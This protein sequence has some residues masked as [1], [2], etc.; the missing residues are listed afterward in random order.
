MK[1][2][3]TLIASATLAS[4][5]ATNVTV[6]S[7]KVEYRIGGTNRYETSNM[8]ANHIY[9]KNV[10]NVILV[11]G[12]APYDALVSSSF[13]KK[14]N[15]PILLTGTNK[16]ESG[17]S[18]NYIK[19]HLKKSG[20]VYILGGNA[21]VSSDT[22]SEIK[23]LGFKI[24]RIC[25]NDRFDTNSKIINELNVKKG[26]PIF[27]VSSNGFGDSLSV[28][29][30]SAIKEY[31]I[32]M[33]GKDKLPTSL[34]NQIE[35]IQPSKVYII[36]S[37]SLISDKVVSEIKNLNK[38]LNESDMLRIYGK[39][40]YQTNLLINKAFN[41]KSS[42]DIIAN[43]EN[44]ADALSGSVLAS[45]LNAPIILTDGKNF[46][47]QKSYINSTNYINHYILGLNGSV[48]KSIENM[49][50]NHNDNKD[51]HEFFS[52]IIN[53]KHVT[54]CELDSTCTIRFSAKDLP[55][56][57]QNGFNQATAMIGDTITLG[58]TG[59]FKCDSDTKIK[60]ELTGTIKLNGMLPVNKLE[61]PMWV[62]IDAS[63][64]LQ[65]KVKCIYKI[66][67]E[68]LAK[69]P[70]SQ[71]VIK[72]LDNK[73]YMVMNLSDMSDMSNLNNGTE[74]VSVDYNKIIGYL[75][76]NK[77]LL[78]KLSAKFA[79][80]FTPN[81]NAIKKQGNIKTPDGRDAVR[82]QLKL[83]TNSLNELIAYT[84]NNALNF[85][86]E[87]EVVDF[88]KAY[89]NV[90][91]DATTSSNLDKNAKLEA[92]TQL[93]NITKA[94]TDNTPNAAL[95]FNKFVDTLKSMDLIG[96]EGIELN[97]YLDNNGR[98]IYEDGTIPLTINL[99]KI[100]KTI[101]PAIANNV[102]GFVNLKISFNTNLTKINDK[103]IDINFPEINE[104][105]SVDYLKFLLS[106]M[107]EAANTTK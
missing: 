65:P 69:L 16:N 25:G 106:T 42:N 102:K 20:T 71:E 28:S 64:E 88:I 78:E 32:I 63:N 30:I 70:N 95:A 44:F 19:Q 90:C 81:I 87:K 97:F 39:N 55:S 34:K 2:I 7:A 5:L 33:T 1:K 49:L 76:N 6:A 100:A 3:K 4:L 92:K 74:N 75:Q 27:L 82:Y 67:K 107:N 9:D 24:K 43:G 46:E 53:S 47:N 15:A 37:E 73:D 72:K 93:N 83:N 18:L 14:I 35:K 66:P 57:A 104:K 99:N 68:Y 11:S 89:L 61:F 77:D 40:R 10:E 60:E 51:T 103:T 22:E 12:N 86:Q 26:T 52:N 21:S 96:N 23:K 45:K 80:N 59:K 8:I 41:L 85:V 105:N 84:G 50:N 48:D 98:I 101:N 56:E 31:P 36:G 13:A 79:S 58:T 91:I 62:D 54:S 29:S 17:P 38:N 94:L